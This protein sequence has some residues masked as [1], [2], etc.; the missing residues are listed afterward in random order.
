MNDLFKVQKRLTNWVESDNVFYA[1]KFNGN[2]LRVVEGKKGFSIEKKGSGWR[3]SGGFSDN[4]EE[5]FALINK[6]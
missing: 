1:T 5:L 6:N 3:R 2:E 4:I